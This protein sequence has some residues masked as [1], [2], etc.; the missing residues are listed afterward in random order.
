MSQT[1]ANDSHWFYLVLATLHPVNTAETA[2]L[3][4]GESLIS[5]LTIKT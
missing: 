1:L 2:G 4:L 5:S 3:Q